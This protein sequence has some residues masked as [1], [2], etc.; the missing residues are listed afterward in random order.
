MENRIT[1]IFVW[2]RK[3]IERSRIGGTTSVI[4]VHSDVSEL[5]DLRLHRF[6]LRGVIAVPADGLFLHPV[7]MDSVCNFIEACSSENLVIQQDAKNSASASIAFGVADS[8][9]ISR[10][11]VHWT[12]GNITDPAPSRLIY[13]GISDRLRVGAA[14]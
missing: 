4:L 10:E 6:F 5:A 3:V 8:L 12:R 1:R 2:P 7:W 9:G 13:Q 11:N 14:P